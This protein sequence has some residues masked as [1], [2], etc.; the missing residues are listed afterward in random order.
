MLV[1]NQRQSLRGYVEN[2]IENKTKIA[3][4]VLNVRPIREAF[5]LKLCNFITPYLRGSCETLSFVRLDDI[6]VAGS[7]SKNS[8][9]TPRKKLPR[10]E[11]AAQWGKRPK[12]WPKLL[13]MNQLF[14]N[15]VS[16]GF[17]G[18]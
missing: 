9:M 4:Q 8:V 10:I 2:S 18:R 11:A 5:S 3:N 13:K 6:Q 12:S 14:R 17:L 1:G 15:L 16:G 7:F